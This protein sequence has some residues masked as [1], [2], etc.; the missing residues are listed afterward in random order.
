MIT[1]VRTALLLSA[2]LVA[3]ADGALA[4]DVIVVVNKDNPV[5]VLSA[6][7]LRRLY[8]GRQKLWDSKTQVVLLLPPI[9]SAALDV[10]SERI[11]AVRGPGAVAAYYLRAIFE[12]RL[13]A[14]PTR[15][16]GPADAVAK[17]SRHRGAIVLLDRIRLPRGGAVRIMEVDGL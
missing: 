11:L 2:C 6:Q 1:L 14:M 5:P 10:L 9:E 7:D 8:R 15:T 17:V 3:G 16:E 13:V 12:G 4:A